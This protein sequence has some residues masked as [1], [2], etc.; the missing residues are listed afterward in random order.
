MLYAEI[1]EEAK[2]ILAEAKL[3]AMLATVKALAEADV[4]AETED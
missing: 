2:A 1:P 3:R 4:K